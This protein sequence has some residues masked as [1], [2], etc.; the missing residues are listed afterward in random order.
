MTQDIDTTLRER[1]DLYGE[2][3]LQAEISQ[4]L[5]EVMRHAP[6]YDD[7]S[8][9]MVEALEMIQHKVARILNGGP[10]YTDSWHD[11]QGYARLVE[12]D[13]L[14]AERQKEGEVLRGEGETRDQVLKEAEWVRREMERGRALLR[15]DGDDCLG[16]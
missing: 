16:R 13:L 15:G 6:H 5:K 4:G 11:I 1:D 12:S 14:D 3:S 2:F 10:S 7:L 8:P 9:A